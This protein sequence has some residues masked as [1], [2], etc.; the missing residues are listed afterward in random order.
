MLLELHGRFELLPGF[1]IFL[2]LF[3]KQI[4]LSKRFY[5][6]LSVVLARTTLP[7]SSHSALGS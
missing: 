5:L 6:P 4:R 3:E 7:L 1:E 2:V